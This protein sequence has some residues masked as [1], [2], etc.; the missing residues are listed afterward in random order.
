[1]STKEAVR[2]EMLTPAGSVGSVETVGATEVKNSFASVM[3]KLDD[4]GVLAITK[5]DKRLGVLLSA[6]SYDALVRRAGDPLASLRDHYDSMFAKMQGPAAAAAAG[7][8]FGPGT[9]LGVKHSSS[10]KKVG[11]TRERT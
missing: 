6:H 4:S 2:I 11:R 10:T 5:H 9:A 8:L 7:R 1:M 3:D